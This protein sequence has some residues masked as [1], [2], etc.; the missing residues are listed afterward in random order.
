MGLTM[1]GNPAELLY[2]TTDHCSSIYSSINKILERSPEY[3]RGKLRE[4]NG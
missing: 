1:F 3:L 2:Y 4:W